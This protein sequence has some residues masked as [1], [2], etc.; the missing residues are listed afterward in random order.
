[1]ARGLDH[2]VLGVRDLDAAGAFYQ[3]LG[4]TVGAVNRHPWGTHNRII[5]FPGVFLELITVGEPEKIV[6]HAPHHF[7][8]GAFVRDALA[9]GEGASMLVLD[10]ADGQ[11]DAAAFASAR[12]GAFEP[13]FFERQGIRPDG[14]SVRVAFTLAFAMSETA[15]DTAF[16]VCQQHEPQNF[17]NPAFQTHANGARTVTSVTFATDNVPAMQPFLVS[18][19]GAASEATQGGS[20]F[21]LARGSI[22]VVHDRLATRGRLTGFTVAVADLAHAERLARDAGAAITHGEWGFA[23]DAFGA[24]LRFVED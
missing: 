9:R 13:F 18:F 10:S 15:P 8:F 1:M 21:A 14:S 3:K 11:G 5:Q 24:R 4:F 16:F 7:S 20:R 12:I 17:W 22:D 6:P 23:V 19:T 2:L